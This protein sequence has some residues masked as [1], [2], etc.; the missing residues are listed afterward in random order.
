MSLHEFFV[1]VIRVTKALKLILL[2]MRVIIC[3]R[4]ATKVAINTLSDSVS[5]RFASTFIFKF[6]NSTLSIICLHDVSQ[7]NLHPNVLL[8]GL[9]QNTDK[10]YSVIRLKVLDNFG[11]KDY[12]CLYR[13]RVHGQAPAVGQA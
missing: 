13:V 3:F 6:S 10:L 2:K 5:L 11:N 4:S 8:V 9:H 12:T 1:S 7:I